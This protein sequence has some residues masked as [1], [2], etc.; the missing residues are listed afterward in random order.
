MKIDKS[1]LSDGILSIVFDFWEIEL[2]GFDVIE[3]KDRSGNFYSRLA[4]II[5]RAVAEYLENHHNYSIV[6]Y[7]DNTNGLIRYK[8]MPHDMC[9]MELVFDEMRKNNQKW[10]SYDGKIWINMDAEES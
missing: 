9:K 1:E 8:I 6:S 5:C 10:L 7:I 4:D 2:M 3:N